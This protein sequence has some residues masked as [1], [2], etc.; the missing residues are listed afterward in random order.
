M[1]NQ[2]LIQ[3]LRF[4]PKRHRDKAIAYLINQTKGRL[5]GHIL[6]NY[7]NYGSNLEDIMSEVIA[8]AYIRLMRFLEKSGEIKK[9]LSDYFLGICRYYLKERIRNNNKY[10]KEDIDENLSID[11]TE[12]EEEDSKIE[13]LKKCMAQL[14]DRCR[15]LLEFKYYTIEEIEQAVLNQKP[16]EAYTYRPR[17]S[18]EVAKKF[19][20]TLG[21]ARQAIHKCRKKLYQLCKNS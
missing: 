12:Q 6:K 13:L 18:E 21:N 3:A 8:E 17:S 7:R 10:P 2:E 14:C 1:K 11:L 5:K 9:S 4:G 20:Y 19:N 16:R 15:E